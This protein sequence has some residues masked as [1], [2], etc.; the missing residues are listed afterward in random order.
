MNWFLSAVAAGDEPIPDATIIGAYGQSTGK[1]TLCEG[2][3]CDYTVIHAIPNPE[4]NCTALSATNLLR[5]INGGAFA[6]ITGE[7][8]IDRAA[9]AEPEGGKGLTSHPNALSADMLKE[10]H[11]N[12]CSFNR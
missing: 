4:G 10:Y 2:L 7:I 8:E 5:F 1:G 12:D 3:D 6:R 9:Q 11:W